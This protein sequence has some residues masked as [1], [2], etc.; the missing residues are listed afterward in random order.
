V[1]GQPGLAPSDHRWSGGTSGLVQAKRAWDR[2][3]AEVDLDGLVA[4]HLPKPQPVWFI[5]GWV[6]AELSK[7]LAEINQLKTLRE[8]S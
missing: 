8:N 2:V 5:A 6:N 4:W 3:L 7:N 1:A